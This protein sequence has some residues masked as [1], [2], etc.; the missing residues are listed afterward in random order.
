MNN[1]EDK[2]GLI[3]GFL[4]I[5]LVFSVGFWLFSLESSLVYSADSDGQAG[6]GSKIEPVSPFGVIKENVAQLVK[7]SEEG[8]QKIKDKFS[9]KD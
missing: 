1:L 8:F 7:I 9:P 3:W 6:M 2:N 4:T 5:L